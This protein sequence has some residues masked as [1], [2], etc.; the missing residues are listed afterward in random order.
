MGT[1]IKGKCK[2]CGYETK[3]LFYGSGFSNLTKCC[4]YPV[5][6]K[7]ENEIK[8]ENIMNRDEVVKQNPRLVFYDDKSLS[9]KN[10]KTKSIM[11]NGV[12]TS[13]IL[14]A[15]S[16]QSVISSVS[17]FRVWLLG[18]IICFTHNRIT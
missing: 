4:A 16:A 3:D 9:D 12:N 10:Y 14:M 8:M 7:S 17:D 18:L 1:I 13:Y 2:N 6:D 11:K 15:I 5:L